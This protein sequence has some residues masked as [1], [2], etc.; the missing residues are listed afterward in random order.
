MNTNKILKGTIGHNWHVKYS[1]RD[2]DKDG[3]IDCLDCDYRNR[4]KQ[5]FFHDVGKMIVKEK[6]EEQGTI[7]GRLKQSA[8]EYIERKEKE[9][10]AYRQARHEERIR[11]LKEK[12]KIQTENKLKRLRSGGVIR[13]AFLSQGTTVGRALV[14]RKHHTHKKRK[15]VK[16]KVI[17]RREAQPQRSYSVF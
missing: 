15:K 12:A 7:K 5:G 13:N 14:K 3:L 1:V 2:R 11:Y 10:D 4:K 6:P 16:T 17:V 9:S 8:R